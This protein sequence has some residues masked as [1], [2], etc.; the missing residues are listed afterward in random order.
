MKISAYRHQPRHGEGEAQAGTE[1]AARPAG[2]SGKV[3]LSLFS[4]LDESAQAYLAEIAERDE[5]TPSYSQ[6]AWMHRMRR[7]PFQHFVCEY[8]LLQT[9]SPSCKSD[10]I[11]MAVF[12]SKL[13]KGTE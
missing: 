2:T 13:Q 9:T 4:Y 11:S 10:G 6:A 7:K 5:T 8:A 3:I 1:R 12:T